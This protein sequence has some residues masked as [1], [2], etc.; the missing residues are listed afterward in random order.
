MCMIHSLMVPIVDFIA[1]R[2]TQI[3]F[4]ITFIG[5]SFSRLYQL[6]PEFGSYLCYNFTS[7]HLRQWPSYI[8]PALYTASKSV[9]SLT[10]IMPSIKY[11]LSIWIVE[12]C[13]FN[14]SITTRLALAYVHDT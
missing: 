11:S 9:W 13:Y 3:C 4:P 1:F 7:T 6:I 2:F 14:F 8:I 10:N 12:T 5:H